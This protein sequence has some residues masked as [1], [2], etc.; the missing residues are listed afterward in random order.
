MWHLNNINKIVYLY[1]GRNKPLSYLRFK[2]VESLSKLN[3]DWKIKVFYPVQI[4]EVETWSS[5]EQKYHSH[6]VPDYFSYLSKFSNVEVESFDMESIGFSND[7]SEVHKSDIIRLYLLKEFGGVWSDFDIFYTRPLSFADFNRQENKDKE[8]FICYHHSYNSVGFLASKKG[9]NLFNDLF[10]AL[11]Y[12]AH[13]NTYQSLGRD[14]FKDVLNDWYV[15]CDDEKTFENTGIHNIKFETVYPYTWNKTDIIFSDEFEMPVE[16]IGVHWYAGSKKSAEIEENLPEHVDLPIVQMMENIEYPKIGIGIPLT[17]DHV[18]SMFMDCLVRLNKPDRF[19]YIRPFF[20]G[21]I[22][23]VRNQLVKQ[24]LKEGCTHLF[25]VDSDQT[26]GPNTL[27]KLY[28]HGKDICGAKVQRRYPVYDA[29]MNLGEPG[30]YYAVPD[31]IIEKNELVEVSATGCGCI[32][33]NTEVFTKVEEPWYKTVKKED[34]KLIGEDIYF[35]QQI[36]NQGYKIFV[37]PMLEDEVEHVTLIGINHGFHKLY[38]KIMGL[39]ARRQEDKMLE[40]D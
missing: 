28:G 10:K 21:P 18:L 8:S 36:K 40:D 4:C 11:K 24:A 25:M 38:K 3:P 17:N 35:H 1:W 32:L 34:G 29:L 33:Y 31:E 20:P 16:S 37:D 9:S 30:N 27:N 7:I 2:T 22:E 23:D 15:D 6:V 13:K 12:N 14:L 5:H 39:S 26:F 19:V